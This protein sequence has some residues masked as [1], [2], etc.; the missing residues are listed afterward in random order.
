MTWLALNRKALPLELD[1]NRS[2]PQPATNDQQSLGL[3]AGEWVQVRSREEILATL[4]EN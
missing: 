3:R 4:D 1:R 2:L